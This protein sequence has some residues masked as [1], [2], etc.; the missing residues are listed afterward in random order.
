VEHLR[1]PV[2]LLLDKVV[3]QEV[4]V[5]AVQVER[6]P[7][8]DKEMQEVLGMHLMEEEVAEQVR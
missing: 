8:L 7:Q 4:E 1:L 5:I 6:L 3:D 2:Q